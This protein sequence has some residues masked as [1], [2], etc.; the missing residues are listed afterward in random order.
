MFCALGTSEGMF[1]ELQIEN[2]YRVRL[3]EFPY[4][5]VRDLVSFI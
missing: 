1:S 4:R 5:Q 3:N 2:K